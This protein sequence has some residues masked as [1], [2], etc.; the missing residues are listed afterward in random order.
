MHSTNVLFLI[1]GVVMLAENWTYVVTETPEGMRTEV[2]SKDGLKTKTF[3]QACHGHV[4]RSALC[5][6]MEHL[7]DENYD[8]FFPRPREKKVKKQS[9]ACFSGD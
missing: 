8:G 7:S 1:K 2:A 5:H 6:F 4:A 9:T 3:F